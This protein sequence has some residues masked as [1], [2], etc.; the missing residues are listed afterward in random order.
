MNIFI[1]LYCRR[2]RPSYGDNEREIIGVQSK[3]SL[4]FRY[5]IKTKIMFKFRLVIVNVRGYSLMCTIQCDESEASI[6]KKYV[7]ASDDIAVV[8][9]DLLGPA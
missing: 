7:E 4:F 5:L 2:W 1:R 3:I 8:R 6:I 9:L